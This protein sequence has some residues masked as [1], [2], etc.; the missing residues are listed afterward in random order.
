MNSSLSNIVTPL[1]NWYHTYARTLPWRQSPSAYHIWVSE[2]MLQQTRVEAV[3]AYYNRFTAELPTIA[4]LAA[5]QEEKL[6]KLWEGLGSVSYTHLDVYKRQ[7]YSFAFY[8]KTLVLSFVVPI[9]RHTNLTD[10]K[11]H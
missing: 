2:I 5:C 10:V 7:V 1:L 3:K 9:A 8:R 6:L 4:D 11:C